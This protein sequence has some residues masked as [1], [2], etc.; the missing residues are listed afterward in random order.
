MHRGNAPRRPRCAR[1]VES[2]RGGRRHGP[3]AIRPPAARPACRQAA[4]GERGTSR[5]GVSNAEPGRD[6][7]CTRLTT[8]LRRRQT[9]QFPERGGTS[10][11]SCESPTRE[12]AMLSSCSPVVCPLAIL[13]PSFRQSEGNHGVRIRVKKHPEAGRLRRAVPIQAEH[14]IP[15]PSSVRWSTARAPSTCRAYKRVMGVH[16]RVAGRRGRRR[17]N[18]PEV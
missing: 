16:G 18:A 14:V 2:P 11:Q 10:S 4:S 3:S 1:P 12:A 7:D 17:G 6:V 5:D 15:R 8:S 13:D 9:S